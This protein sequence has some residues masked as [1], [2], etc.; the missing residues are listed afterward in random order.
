MCRGSDHWV[1]DHW[2]LLCVPSRNIFNFSLSRSHSLI[3]QFL[4]VAY[5]VPGPCQAL[6][7]LQCPKCTQACSHDDA[8]LSL[9]LSLT[10]HFSNMSISTSSRTLTCL[11]IFSKVLLGKIW[12]QKERSNPSIQLEF[13][14]EADLDLHPGR[15]DDKRI[16][17]PWPRRTT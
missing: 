12:K 7:I 14:L 5:H 9:P 17:S 15:L 13:F 2:V 10:L 8:N 1:E 4:V 16:R 6:E 11:F 3:S